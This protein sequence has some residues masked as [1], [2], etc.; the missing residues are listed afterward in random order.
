MEQANLINFLSTF[1]LAVALT[2]FLTGIVLRYALARGV[3][4]VPSERSAHVVPTPRGGGLAMVAV[5]SAGI[6]VLCWRGTVAPGLATALIGGSLVTAAVGWADDRRGLRASL[7]LIAHLFAATWAVFWLGGFPQLSVGDAEFRLGLSG[8]IL[9]VLAI[10]WLINLYNFMDGIDGIAGVTALVVA[11][12]GAFFL[13]S[14]GNVD[15]ANLALL[16]AGASLGFLVYNWSPARIFLGDVGS[17]SLGLYFGVLAIA[18]ENSRTV[19]FMV[20]MFLLGVFL[21]DATVTLLRRMVRGEQ[22]YK[23]HNN[24][25]YQRAV[26]AGYSHAQVSL[27]VALINGLVGVGIIITSRAGQSWMLLGALELAAL[28]ALYVGVEKLHPM[29]RADHRRVG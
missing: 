22:W 14:A 19:P 3:L 4:D 28:V 25:A 16:I 29:R 8:S 12:F 15:L 21:V 9:A 7:R 17:G 24:H 23:A 20:W 11:G 27:A 26:R 2:W 6:L 1:L 13:A 10:V 18:S 5:V